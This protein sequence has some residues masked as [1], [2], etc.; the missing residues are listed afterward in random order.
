M[1]AVDF[2][3][4]AALAAVGVVAG[5]VADLPFSRRLADAGRSRLPAAPAQRVRLRR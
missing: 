4:A 2:I 3:A 5:E 1:T